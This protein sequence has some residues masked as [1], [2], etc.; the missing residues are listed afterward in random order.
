M[1]PG[2]SKQQKKC[3][4]ASQTKNKK[5]EKKKKK[6]EQFV[7]THGDKDLSFGEVFFGLMNKNFMFGRKKG[8]TSKQHPRNHETQ[9]WQQQV[10][11]ETGMYH[12]TGGIMWKENDTG[13][14]K[15]YLKG[16]G[17]IY[18]I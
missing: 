12:K 10:A 15:Q 8:S 6:E 3:S 7:P 17:S 9:G 13:I 1:G 11:G 2:T 5:M 16:L 4:K 14:I 18:W